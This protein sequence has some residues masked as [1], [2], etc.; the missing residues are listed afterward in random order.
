MYLTI[1][2]NKV[3]SRVSNGEGTEGLEVDWVKTLLVVSYLWCVKF[4][5]F[6]FTITRF[7]VNPVRTNRDSKNSLQGCPKNKSNNYVLKTCRKK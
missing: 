7:N 5:F 3:E 1:L 6:S 4:F 2:A